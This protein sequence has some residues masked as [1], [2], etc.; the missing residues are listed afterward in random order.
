M[1]K[2]LI[3]NL[4]SPLPQAILAEYCTGFWNK[5][6]G[7]ML[8]PTLSENSGI[9]LVESA[10]SRLSTAIHMLFMRFDITAIWVNDQMEV[11]DVKIARKWRPSYM[12]IAPARYVMETHVR[13]YQNFHIGD[14]VRFAHA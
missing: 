6:K 12:P 13:H 8:C 7:L 1:R 10:D 4:S 11:V 2:V 3:Q 14:K 9:I 5:F